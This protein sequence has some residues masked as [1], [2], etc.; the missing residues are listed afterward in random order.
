MHLIGKETQVNKRQRPDGSFEGDSK[1]QGPS[2][3]ATATPI[4][5]GEQFSWADVDA[6]LMR[7]AITV[8]TDAGDALSF[9]VNRG[10]TSG[11]VVVLSGSER[12]RFFAQSTV[13]AEQIL[14]EIIRIEML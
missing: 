8:A 4:D 12:P 14:Q 2:R 3:W 5:V 10:H 11:S 7:N 6:E 13:A 9:A 1:K